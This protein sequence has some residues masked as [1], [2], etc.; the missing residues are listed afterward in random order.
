MIVS[1]LQHNSAVPITII[2]TH[3]VLKKNYVV[4]SLNIN[5]S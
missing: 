5:L 1:A 2:Q 4:T 3:S